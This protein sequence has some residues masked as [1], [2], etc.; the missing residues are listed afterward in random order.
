MISTASCKCNHSL[1]ISM[2][3]LALVHLNQYAVGDWVAQIKR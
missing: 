1:A 2:A 3:G